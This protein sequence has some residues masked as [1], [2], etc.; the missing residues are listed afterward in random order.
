MQNQFDKLFIEFPSL[1]QTLKSIPISDIWVCDPLV[2][3][4][5]SPE[6]LFRHG[7]ATEQAEL[8]DLHAVNTAIRKS[9]GP[10]E[11][12]LVADDAASTHRFWV[13]SVPFERNGTWV[14]L[15]TVRDIS[16]EYKLET[17]LKAATRQLQEL[18]FGA[19][20]SP[21]EAVHLALNDELTGIPNRRAFDKALEKA[22]VRGGSA[23]CL[24]DMDRFKRV[25]DSL[26]HAV[27]DKLLRAVAAKLAT[28][29]RGRD[30]VGRLAG[31]EFAVIL[32]D[33]SD[34]LT[35]RDALERLLSC[36]QSRL[37]LG[38]VDI[39]VSL[40]GGV[41]M[42]QAGDD[43]GAVFR[44]ADLA[45]HQAKKTEH[46]RLAVHSADG[47]GLDEH[48]DLVLVKALLTGGDVPLRFDAMVDRQGN[49]LAYEARVGGLGRDID[50]VFATAEKFGLSTEFLGALLRRVCA[51]A[52]EPVT[53]HAI[54][55][56]LPMGAYER[57]SLPEQ[58]S[59]T[60]EDAGLPEGTL[61]LD[62][63]KPVL[64][65]AQSLPVLDEL[66]A[67]GVG[68]VLCDWD[69]GLSVAQQLA[70]G[71]F[72][73]AKLAPVDVPALGDDANAGDL[74]GAAVGFVA[75]QGADVFAAG[76]HTKH[77]ADALFEAGVVAVQGGAAEPNDRRGD[78]RPTF[79]SAA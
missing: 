54:H 13:K 15:V 16:V 8:L 37:D 14:I 33:V 6:R 44:K 69:F 45:L 55:L 58:V 7:N 79:T 1:R 56:R 70:R 35:A 43:P 46:R 68:L 57:A 65:R 32:N 63:P 19:Q 5:I 66:R 50:A 47:A 40:S 18:E 20:F 29:T 27:G 34:Q 9:T 28:H 4:P 24:M 48:D 59:A 3:D 77:D 17:A 39:Q 75:N 30:F 23:L 41:A 36:F 10:L 21:D 60:L 62:V 31:D 49:T 51:A 73:A 22:C 42:I 61:F 64:E 12:M 74:L 25:N 2:D 11:Q 71:T 53:A 67:K 26:G 72:A 38:D 76:V 78:G 52:T